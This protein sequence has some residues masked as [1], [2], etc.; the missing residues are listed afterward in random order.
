MCCGST[1]IYPHKEYL[2]PRPP[3]NNFNPHPPRTQGS[4]SSHT[5]PA[6]AGMRNPRGLTRSGQD[7]IRTV[8]CTCYQ[9]NN[10]RTATYA[11]QYCLWRNKQNSFHNVITMDDLIKN[12]SNRMYFWTTVAEIWSALLILFDLLKNAFAFLA[13]LTINLN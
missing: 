5:R 9:S 3:R 12:Y 4:S 11:V 6:H 2:N 1:L 7:S 13:L 10:C 8:Y